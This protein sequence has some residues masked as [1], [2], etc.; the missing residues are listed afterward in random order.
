[1]GG[2]RGTQCRQEGQGAN[3]GH[4][5]L[6]GVAGGQR[7]SGVCGVPVSY[8]SIYLTGTDAQSPSLFH[9]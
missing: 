2:H 5:N 4:D 1:M 6:E 7:V 9:L 3:E 8:L